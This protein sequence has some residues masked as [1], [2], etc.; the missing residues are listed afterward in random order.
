MLAM[1]EICSRCPND[2]YNSEP[3]GIEGDPI[4]RVAD[5]VA[6]ARWTCGISGRLAA[7]RSMKEGEFEDLALIDGSVV[8]GAIFG[9]EDKNT[10]IGEVNRWVTPDGAIIANNADGDL[11]YT[12]Q[13][14]LKRRV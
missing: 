8:A 1:G 10:T 3:V 7:R 9:S 14:V 13:N 11:F 2:C 6:C 5:I 4:F 12:G